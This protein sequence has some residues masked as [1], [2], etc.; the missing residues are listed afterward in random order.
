MR[1][2][3][4]VLLASLD[5]SLNGL[6][7]VSGVSKMSLIHDALVAFLGPMGVLCFLWGWIGPCGACCGFC[8]TELALS[9]RRRPESGPRGVRTHDPRIKRP[10]GTSPSH[11]HSGPRSPA[12]PG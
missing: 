1:R 4:V 8:G 11:A 10:W 2:V 12:L 7:A 9:T 6:V 5:G 3:E